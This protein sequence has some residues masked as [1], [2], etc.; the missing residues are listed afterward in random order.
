[1]CCNCDYLFLYAQNF[2]KV[3]ET[4][5]LL[6][7][8]KDENKKRKFDDNTDTGIFDLN[9]QCWSFE[10]IINCFSDVGGGKRRKGDGDLIVF[11]ASRICRVRQDVERCV[12][13]RSS[14]ANTT[15]DSTCIDNTLLSAEMDKAKL[16]MKLYFSL[17]LT[18]FFPQLFN[19]NE[20]ICRE[21]ADILREGV[22][23]ELHV[24]RLAQHLF[25]WVLIYLVQ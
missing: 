14:T 19:S 15:T 8:D 2:L 10:L 6:S 21:I 4:R 20:G 11:V 25:G 3:V 18:S 17:R 5:L 22:V 23:E 7:I 9:N 16:E 24:K 13:W 12:V 1:M